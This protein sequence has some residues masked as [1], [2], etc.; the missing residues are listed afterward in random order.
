[1]RYQQT[2]I[3]NLWSEHGNVAIQTG[4]NSAF[5]NDFACT[6]IAIKGRTSRHEGSIT[7]AMSRCNNTADVDL[8]SWREVHTSGVQQIHLTIGSEVTKNLTRVW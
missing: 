8:R 7:H 2:G 3:A 5:V 4:L 6:T 1:L